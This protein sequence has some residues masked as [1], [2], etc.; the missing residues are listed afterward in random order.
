MYIRPGKTRRIWVL[1][2][3]VVALAPLMHL[4]NREASEN[5]LGPYQFTEPQQVCIWAALLEAEGLTYQFD[6]KTQEFYMSKQAAKRFKKWKRNANLSP[7]LTVD[8]W[9]KESADEFESAEE[10]RLEDQLRQAVNLSFPQ[11]LRVAKVKVRSR[12]IEV[13]RFPECPSFDDGVIVVRPVAQKT[14]EGP[15]YS[16]VSKHVFLALEGEFQKAELDAVRELSN[17]AVELAPERGDTLFVCTF[18]HSEEFRKTL[19]WSEADS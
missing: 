9:V 17:N 11:T 3:A 7:I 10:R 6:I 16:L 8:Q 1:I 13:E 15:R 12:P 14:I 18:P 4:L 19:P 5:L 2:I